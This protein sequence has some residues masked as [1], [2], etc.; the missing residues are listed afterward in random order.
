MSLSH[1]HAAPWLLLPGIAL[2]LSSVTLLAPH[3]AALAAPPAPKA[4]A[5]KAVPGPQA[6]AEDDDDGDEL[7]EHWSDPQ[8]SR[9]AQ[10]QMAGMA[11]G[12]FVL[13]AAALRRRARQASRREAV[14]LPT[15]AD[16]LKL[17]SRTSDAP[18]AARPRTTRKAA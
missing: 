8:F 18:P 2:T 10:R 3:G 11:A 16:F 14:P 17:D 7:L 6:V 4:A 1:F 5:L 9:E 13:G 15:E 12:F